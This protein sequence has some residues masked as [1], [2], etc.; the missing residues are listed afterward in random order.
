MSNII[1]RSGELE[2]LLSV[3]VSILPTESMYIYT[4]YLGEWELDGERVTSISNQHVNPSIP[5]SSLGMFGYDGQNPYLVKPLWGFYS[6]PNPERPIRALKFVRRYVG[7]PYFYSSNGGLLADVNANVPGLTG[8]TSAILMKGDL[9][10]SSYGPFIPPPHIPMSIRLGINGNKYL[11]LWSPNS[12][13]T[14]WQLRYGHYDFIDIPP[15]DIGSIEQLWTVIAI[16]HDLPTKEVRIYI[17]GVFKKS[18]TYPGSVYTE[19]V[20]YKNM[21]GNTTS[22]PPRYCLT[23]YIAH[24]AAWAR[25]LSDTDVLNHYN[26]I[27]N[28]YGLIGG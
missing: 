15:A 13:N 8:V 26:Y 27:K 12:Y 17:N 14:N 9:S 18:V 6:Q 23:G 1:T 5:V 25:T 24:T 11:E 28:K 4:D 10:I 21:Y 3:D 16:T 19:T 7:E 22:Y 20:I 2:K